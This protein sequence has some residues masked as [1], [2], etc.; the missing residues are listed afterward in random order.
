MS[1]LVHY[2]DHS[3]IHEM[4]QISFIFGRL[5]I[6]DVTW[7]RLLEIYAAIF[8]KLKKY[9]KLKIYFVNFD[10]IFGLKLKFE[11]AYWIFMKQ[12]YV[13]KMKVN[14]KNESIYSSSLSGVYKTIF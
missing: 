7:E 6:S 12:Y 1:N 9:Y 8:L 5:F 2:A 4:Y 11:K 14:N 10:K 13:A 3:I